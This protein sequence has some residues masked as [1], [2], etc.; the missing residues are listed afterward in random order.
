[1]A[2]RIKMKLPGFLLLLLLSTTTT[3]ATTSTA[4]TTK[5][6]DTKVKNMRNME[7]KFKLNQNTLWAYRLR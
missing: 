6:K 4:T 5:V 7:K 1:M 2:Y 3:N